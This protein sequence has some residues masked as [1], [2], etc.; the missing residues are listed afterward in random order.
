MK[1][2]QTQQ[3][4]TENVTKGRPHIQVKEALLLKRDILVKELKKIDSAIIQLQAEHS[5]KI[6]KLQTERK[7]SEEALHH[8]DALLKLE[9]F[10]VNESQNETDA[11]NSSITSAAYVTDATFNLLEDIHKPMHYKKIALGL[12]EQGIYI[13]GKNPAATLLSRI[14]R[15]SRFKRTMKRGTYALST[16]RMRTSKSKRK[17]RSEKRK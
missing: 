16:W 6:E 9:G 1:D 4:L 11:T 2:K 7:H 15:D 3:I 17:K 12:Q 14:A 13:P 10:A 8:V 5:K